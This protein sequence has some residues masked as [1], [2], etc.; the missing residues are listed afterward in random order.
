MRWSS[1]GAA[2]VML[3]AP[4]SVL[5]QSS[6]RD[7][8]EKLANPISSLI[9]VPFQSNYD[10]CFGPNNAPRYLLN[11]QPVV[12]ISLNPD[13][14]LIVRTILPVIS[15]GSPAPTIPSSTGLGDITQSF[16]FS[17]SQT[18]NGVT[19]GVGP[20]FLWPTGNNVFGSQKW[21]AAPTAVI[22]KQESGWIYG[23]LANHI[24]SYAGKNGS[25]GRDR[26]E[27]EGVP[28]VNQTFI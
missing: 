6:D 11:I 20:V 27:E 16:F 17:P 23:I 3:A 28:E 21:G 24:W 9:S 13:W 22:L 10:C 1:V 4:G 15:M 26:F 14:N 2:I 19:W 5:A 7:L 12:P 8:A 25:Q 18:F